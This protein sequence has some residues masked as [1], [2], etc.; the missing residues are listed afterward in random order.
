MEASRG[1][2]LVALA[3]PEGITGGW[4]FL[5][6]NTTDG[7]HGNGLVVLALTATGGWSFIPANTTETSRVD[8]LSLVL[9]AGSWG[10]LPAKT[11]TSCGIRLVALVEPA[12]GWGNAPRGRWCGGG[13]RGSG[14]SCTTKASRGSCVIT[15]IVL[16][17]ATGV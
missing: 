3:V 11:K 9:S 5:Q 6:G 13:D 10:V 8:V 4:G 2:G 14:S 17:G 7:S 12:G 16:E 15:L 1:N